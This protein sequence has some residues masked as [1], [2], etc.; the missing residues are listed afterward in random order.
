MTYV[1]LLGIDPSLRFTGFGV[2]YVHHHA[3]HYVASEI[4]LINGVC[5]LGRP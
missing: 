4:G 3:M 1:R 2:I 5:S